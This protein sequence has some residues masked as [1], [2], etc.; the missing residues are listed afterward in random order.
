MVVAV[1]IELMLAVAIAFLCKTKYQ[2]LLLSIIRVITAISIAIAC[3][4]YWG[5]CFSY[6]QGVGAYHI[7]F[8]PCLVTVTVVGAYIT[9]LEHGR[10]K[11]EE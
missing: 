10:Q 1:A 11:A 3:L 6:S 7:V 2:R 8:L 9:G 4:E 5:V